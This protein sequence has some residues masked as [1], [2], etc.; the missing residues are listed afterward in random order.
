MRKSTEE[1]HWWTVDRF[2]MYQVPGTK[3]EVWILNLVTQR[4][5]CRQWTVDRW[6]L[7][8]TTVDR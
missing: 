4:I 3:Y 8:R 1:L 2:K 5:A 7:G 6:Q